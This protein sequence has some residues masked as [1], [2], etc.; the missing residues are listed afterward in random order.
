MFALLLAVLLTLVSITGAGAAPKGTAVVTLTVDQTSFT[1][2]ESI[3][4][5]VLIENQ[6]KNPV[7]VLK[8]YT[9]VEDVEEPFFAVFRDGESINYVGAHYKRPAPTGND[10]VVLKGGESFTSD[11]DL[12]AF[13]DLSATGDYSVT[14]DVASW[15]LFSEKGSEN[16]AVDSL[17]SN[18][19]QI[20]IEG[21]APAAVNNEA[22][23]PAAVTGGTT[24]NKCTVA[25]Q[26][27][28]TEARAASSNYAVG[29]LNYLN[30]NSNS[31]PTLRYSTWFGAQ[32]PSRYSTVTS[33]FN[34]I[35]NAMSTASVKF[36]CGC[37]KSYYAYVYSNQPYTII[38]LYDGCVSF[39]LKPEEG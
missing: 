23:S 14:Y 4:I 26:S 39:E 13:Y 19:L 33:H 21:R 32:S 9:P 30:T 3:V 34:S 22:V 37:K 17:S 5:H 27:T 16:K 2:S 8:W 10:Y 28:L 24:F 20:S 36:D 15:N 38:R 1:S 35:N 31:Q 25:Q 11:V 7:K 12:G 18:T 6:G 29:A